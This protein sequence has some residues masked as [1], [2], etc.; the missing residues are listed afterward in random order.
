MGAA[1]SSL[2]DPRGLGGRTLS[3]FLVLEV[4]GRG[5]MGVV[6]KAQDELLRRT[7]AIKVLPPDFVV[8]TEKRQRFLR[9]ARTAA[10]VTHPNIATV[11]EVGEADGIIFIAMELVRGKGLR[12]VTLGEAQPPA[13]A[14]A[15]AAEIAR[16]LAR[17][18][19][20]GIVHR[21]LKPENVMV[22]GDE[23]KLLDFGFARLQGAEGLTA[24]GFIVGTPEYMPPEQTLHD[25]TG[26]RSD[27]Y[28]LGV[29][30]Y[31]I[32]TGRLPFEGD[33][34]ALLAQHLFATPRPP[35]AIDSSIPR[36]V[37]AIVMT[38][39][40][41]LPRNRYPSMQDLVEDLE[42]AMHKR[43]GNVTT[44][45]EWNDVYEPQTPF[46]RAIA[47]KFRK[48]LPAS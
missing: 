38:T 45:L 43:P 31:R 30:L 12:E 40:R 17:A 35:S 47:E 46:A 28:A 29:V 19:A 32:I 6:Y 4:I 3:H 27:I 36:D 16:A 1:S 2:S 10:A 34:P 5:G 26:S 44:M 15:L 9:E 14:L 20:A 41:K 13:R 42:R 37:D 39:L 33:P 21:D 8:D 24:K 7:V 18:H 23:V 22:S 48:K 25:P 11:Y